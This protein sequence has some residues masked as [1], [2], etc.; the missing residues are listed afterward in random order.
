MP[1][2]DQIDLLEEALVNSIPSSNRFITY[3]ATGDLSVISVSDIATFV[4]GDV[5]IDGINSELDQLQL[6]LAD[7][8]TN[9]LPLLQSQLDQLN[10]VE[11]PALEADLGHLNTIQLPALEADLD[12]LN[13]VDLPALDLRLTELD[14][15]LATLETVTLPNLQSQLDA[16]QLSL[17][18]LNNVQLPDLNNRLGGAEADLSELKTVTLPNLDSQLQ[19]NNSTL[20]TLNNVTLPSLDSR[21]ADND[22][23]LNTLNTVDLPALDARIGAN[24]SE[25]NTLNTVDLPA[26]DGR[27]GT[28][29][30]DINTLEITTIPALDTRIGAN[31]SDINTLEITTIPALDGRIDATESDISTLEITTIPALDT[32]I[33][34]NESD[35]STLNTTTLPDLQ[36]QLNNKLADSAGS[37]SLNNFASNISAIEKVDALPTAGNAGRVVLLSTDNTLYRDT[38]IEW[39]KEVSASDVTGQITGTQITDNAITT[40]KIATDA[41]VASNI[42]VDDLVAS[43]AFLNEFT[44]LNGFLDKLFVNNAFAD[45]ITANDISAGTITA[46]EIGANVI[47]A[48]E[49]AVGTITASEIGAGVITASEIGAGVITATEIATGTITASEIGAGVITASEIGANV[50][51]ASEISVDDLVAS[52]AFFNEFTALNGFLDKLFVNNAYADRITANEIG[53]GAVTASEIS[54]G[55]ITASEIASNAITANEINVG[56]ITATEI[57]TGAITANEIASNT[58]TANEISAGTI[59]ATEIA[60]GTVTANE[61]NVGNLVGDTAFYNEFTALNGFL[62][63]LFVNNAFADRITANEIAVDAVTASAISAGTITATEIATGTITASEIGAGAITASEISANAVTTNKIATDA[64]TA[65]EILADAITA[66]E[67]ATDTI[68]A[69][70][71][72]VG[73]LVGSTAFF[74]EY[75]AVNG[76]LDNL[77][78]NNAFADRITANEL[79]VDSITANA[80]TAGTITATEIAYKTLTTDEISANAIT[81]NEINV[82]DLTAL[83]ATIANWGIATNTIDSTTT[84]GGIGLDSS[85]PEFKMSAMFGTELKDVLS[86]RPDGIP[87]AIKSYTNG[88]VVGGTNGVLDIPSDNTSYISSVGKTQEVTIVSDGANVVY[89]YNLDMSQ[90]DGSVIKEIRVQLLGVTRDINDNI[91]K[92]KRGEINIYSQDDFQFMFSTNNINGESING[93]LPDVEEHYISVQIIKTEETADYGQVSLTGITYEETN[94]TIAINSNGIFRRI[95]ADTVESI[96]GGGQVSTTVSSVFGKTGDI[97]TSDIPVGSITDS[98]LDSNY[99]LSGHSH[100]E[101]DITDLGNYAV[102]GHSH[103]EYMP[104]TGGTFSDSVTIQKAVT[105]TPA[106]NNN[107]FELYN[108]SSVSGESVSMSFHLGGLTAVDMWVEHDDPQYLQL[109]HNIKINGATVW[110][111]GNF[112]PAT[113]SDTGHAHSGLYFGTGISGMSGGYN[114]TGSGTISFDTTW[115]DG[116][117]ALSGHTHSNF[118]GT[119]GFNSARFDGTMY[120]DAGTGAHIQADARVRNTNYSALH[121]YG[122][123]DAGNNT[124]VWWELYDGNSYH[125]LTIAN[126]DLIYDGNEVWDAGNFNPATKADTGHTHPWSDITGEPAYTT[127]WP[128]F[129]EVGGTISN[130]QVPTTLSIYRLNS[131][132]TQMYIEAGEMQFS[133]GGEVVY[134]GGEGGVQVASSNSNSGNPDNITTLI[135]AS[136]NAYFAN[137]VTVNGNFYRGNFSIVGN[138]PIIDLAGS[139]L[140]L[141]GT[142]GTDRDA[143]FWKHDGSS[144]WGNYIDGSGTL[145]F[146]RLSGSGT[147]Y[148]QSSARFNGDVRIHSGSDSRLILDNSGSSSYDVRLETAYDYDGWFRVVDGGGKVWFSVGR[149]GQAY[150][151]GVTGNKI[152]HQ[153]N[154]GAGS[155]LDADLLDGISS[156]GFLRSN[157]DD[158]VYGHTEWQDGKNVRFGTHADQRFWHS[159]GHLYIKNYN[160]SGG[161][162]YFQGEDPQGT[163]HALMYLITSSSRPYIRLFENGGE[164]LRTMSYGVRVYGRSESDDHRDPSDRRIKSNLVPHSAIDIADYVRLYKYNKRGLEHPQYGII[165]QD[166]MKY[167]RDLVNVRQDDEFGE[168]FTLSS[169]SIS[170]IALSGVSEL[171]RAF[172]KTT[173]IQTNLIADLRGRVAMLEHKFDELGGRK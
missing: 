112:D 161:N 17:N 152:W 106:Y 158:T 123:D 139:R 118:G 77:F 60:T 31:E 27:I 9:K 100:T 33:G 66:N 135:D 117:Y 114:G 67:I 97:T 19:T 140:V 120:W 1:V 56:T 28:A 84:A 142:T 44:A 138:E 58:I 72:S 34:A 156:G 39:T 76:F 172:T 16:N 81:A 150:I 6:D 70:E 63:N 162:F 157:A 29:E 173:D 74:N 109:D 160:H 154:D 99:A 45:R 126:N 12:Q 136:A 24:D 128:N 86:I 104:K 147:F 129:S 98:M 71:I 168:I 144:I 14:G 91:T 2:L 47:T 51:T 32:R 113:K 110:H 54:A 21:I 132:G 59:T 87:P 53:A 79:A 5:G 89:E 151:N 131:T 82:A 18:D 38:G 69:N 36:T 165:A 155:G 115:G 75:T 88:K 35:I 148:V 146:T 65:N 41:V 122:K 93:A 149:N 95:G 124:A 25:L 4:G 96:G 103:S 73:N 105:G 119:I 52:T 159:G 57:A 121:W 107:T 101:A 164:R 170:S 141:D 8:N 133:Q 90:A 43:T 13:T 40:P 23:E 134:I 3:S 68:T 166:I 26:L 46:S 48:N 137:N 111:S 61:I 15:D 102:V 42:Q 145:R 22:S 108:P 169:Y 153:G 37:V 94:T 7:L 125:S 85:K 64:I 62:D 143:I 171:N 30:S 92:F 116:R 80:I 83:G 78:V 163:N 20:D 167:D 130:S 11:I 50:I 10:D 127:R 55:T 49:I